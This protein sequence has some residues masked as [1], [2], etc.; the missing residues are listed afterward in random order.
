MQERGGTG[1]DFLITFKAATMEPGADVAPTGPVTFVLMN[2]SDA[3]HD[4]CLVNMGED[5]ATGEPAGG[6]RSQPLRAGD[7][8]LVAMAEGVGPGDSKSM[9]VELDAGR[10]CVVSNSEGEYL[11]TALF[12]LTVQ[13][14]DGSEPV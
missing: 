11:G 4:F 6:P 12:E 1:Q 7:P 13:P 8:T 2:E 14:V 5:P 3:T 10:Y 9:T